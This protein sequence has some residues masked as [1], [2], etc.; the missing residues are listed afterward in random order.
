MSF[1]CPREVCLLS[2]GFL[3]VAVMKEVS[4]IVLVQLLPL[5]YRCIPFNIL[6]LWQPPLHHVS[7]QEDEED[8]SIPRNKPGIAW[9]VDVTARF[10]SYATVGWT[11]V[12]LA[13]RVFDLVQI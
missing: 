6:K 2:A 7:Q 3:L 4:K 9:D 8:K 13:P 10:I 12:E 1:A 11:V 5:V